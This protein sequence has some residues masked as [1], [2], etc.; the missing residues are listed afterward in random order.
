MLADAVQTPARK[1][2]YLLD[3]GRL[4]GGRGESGAASA[5]EIIAEAVALGA[6][7]ERVARERERLAELARDPDALLSALEARV[8]LATEKFGPSG[9]QPAASDL[10]DGGSPQDRGAQLRQEIVSL[11]RRQA[12]VAADG[13][14][15]AKAW[16]FLE[17]AAALAPGEPLLLTDLADLAE[18]SGR[19]EDL[20][21]LCARLASLDAD[22]GRAVALGL[23]RA[24]ALLRA[25]K[26]DEAD[27]VLDGVVASAPGYLPV[28][29]LRERRAL[30]GGA[31]ERMA[32]LYQAEA[33]AA[34]L[35]TV[36][37]PGSQVDADPRWAAAAYVAAG[38]VYALRLGREDDARTAYAQALEAAPGYAPAIGALASL[39]E[40]AGRVADACEL[41]EAQWKAAPAGEQADEILER[42]ATLYDAQA[43]PEEALTAYRRLAEHRSGD[44]TLLWRLA[45]ALQSAGRVEEY[46]QLLDR[47]AEKQDDPARRAAIQLEAA[48]VYDEELDK[49]ELAAERYRA[50][51]A[52]VPGDRYARGA[53]VALLRRAGKWEELVAERRA[54]AEAA[55]EGAQ[56]ARALREA[57]AIL[58]RKLG[59]PAEAAAIYQELG[60]R[61]PDDLGALRGL[62]GT[63]A[64]QPT[65]L[66]AV[67]EREVTLVAPGPEQARTLLRLGEVYET[68]GRDADAAISYRRALETAEGS[69]P[70]I[71]THAGWALVTLAARQ[72]DP[73]ALAQAFAELVPG[74][75]DD[76]VR[77]DLLE[78][79]AWLQAADAEA[80]SARF[81]EVLEAAPD[82][83]GALLGRALVAA[84]KKDAVELAHALT[85]QAERTS[86]RRVAG[87]LFL[88]AATLAEVA[89]AGDASALAARALALDPD[90]PG[91]IL[92]V[93]ERGG[94]PLPIPERS[95]V[96][97]RRAAFVVDPATRAELEL[98][99]ARELAA[100]GHLAEAGQA[101]GA[102]LASQPEH[103]AA[104]DELCRVARQAG[105]KETLAIASYKL[106]QLFTDPEASATALADAA[107]LLEP[108]GGMAAT[109][110]APELRPKLLEA[111]A[112]WRMVLD[113]NPFHEEAFA[114]AREILG[115]TDASGAF[116]GLLT[117]RIEHLGDPVSET[118]HLMERAALRLRRRALSAAGEDLQ[119]VLDGDP[120]HA[121]AL[122]Q[123]A[124][125]RSLEGNAPEAA[126]LLERYLEVERDPQRIAR[127]E[128]ELAAVL[129][130][131]M[132]D[133]DGAIRALEKVLETTPENVEAHEKLIAVLGTKKDHERV[134]EEMSKLGARRGDRFERAKDEL[135]AAWVYRHEL[136]DDDRARK[137]LERARTLDPLNLDVVREL[138]NVVKG[139]D[140]V[141]ILQ[142]ALADVR[143]ALAEY[144]TRPPLY[145]RFVSVSA[146]LPDEDAQV[147][148]AGALIALDAA[149]PEHKTI[150]EKRVKKLAGSPATPRRSLTAADWAKLQPATAR[151]PWID[152][153]LAIAESAA[154][155]G[156][157]EPAQLGF[158]KGDRV[159]PKVVAQKHP[160]VDA[161]LRAFAIEEV[162]LYV[163]TSRAG[164]ARGIALETPALFLGAD[165]AKGET[166]QARFRLGRAL[167]ELH[168]RSGALEDG[169]DDDLGLLLAA[170]VRLG[171]GDLGRVAALA[172][173]ERKARAG[174]I[175][176][177]AKALGKASSRKDKKAL[178]LALSRLGEADDIGAWR[179]AMRETT[180]RAALIVCGDLA[181]ALIE[182]D[183]TTKDIVGDAGALDLLAFG[184]SEEHLQ[185]RKDLGL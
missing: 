141:V 46:A 92:G 8:A 41:L 109:M 95:A 150:V 37:G 172:A 153:W 91:A 69:S 26:H 126:A 66:A 164:Y 179:A 20:A 61:A 97:A 167:A 90:D 166:P 14:D 159:A 4:V 107:R 45:D 28:T 54:E 103:I 168:E 71:G 162:D 35:G 62:A 27:G 99:R 77:A 59:R 145:E 149:S 44:G 114:R 15:A 98:E 29:A 161:W 151:E 33:A 183:P 51:L 121:D 50:V 19:A 175:D 158:V 34:R 169:S 56:V 9:P 106:G 22:P 132:G 38:D 16:Q 165:V 181:T 113:R 40:R 180:R 124:H 137:A 13:G 123:L 138:A 130:E 142:N 111:A 110:H 120:L 30:E 160:L 116:E 65:E 52:Q 1:V 146:M 140:R 75:V 134:A 82:R 21:A 86:D 7:R 176:E 89:N 127:A 12:H 118:P 79:I 49:P 43:K 101:L 64:A 47:L 96:L 119:R 32:G 129:A 81:A 31:W 2:G 83:R 11:R 39:H 155:L 84:R 60:D 17:Q 157:H 139:E 25:G 48:R 136:H 174:A 102:V 68:L 74:R 125:V 18:D 85:S 105:D 135:R 72:K 36:F 117:H 115:G 104:L 131:K 58:E 152:L 10:P 24:D 70:T 112:V 177:R 67:L 148:A 144:P 55:G 133:P 108:A 3:L 53:L 171:G 6:D 122:A 73:N 23:R 94:G 163:S 182:L 170:A 63:L 93:A 184:V 154:R 42:L 100:A 78:E 143:A 80:A 156:A 128:L 88:R 5:L 76:V 57:A 178:P 173:I 185:L 147:F 87:A